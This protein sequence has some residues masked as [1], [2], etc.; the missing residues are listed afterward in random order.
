MFF[1]DPY[2]SPA[3]L[4]QKRPE[5]SSSLAPP[6]QISGSNV[7]DELAQ[8][9]ADL[10]PPPPP[11]PPELPCWADLYADA[12]STSFYEQKLHVPKYDFRLAPRHPDKPQFTTWVDQDA[13]A[14]Y[15]PC[16]RFD[17][18]L[19][20]PSE[21]IPRLK[22]PRL[23][24]TFNYGE[25]RNKRPKTL[26]WQ[27]GRLEGKRLVIIFKFT[28]ARIQAVLEH[29]GDALSNWPG[30][31]F[32]S[33]DG[34]PDWEARWSAQ[35]PVLESQLN[36]D[37]TYCLRDRA[38]LGSVSQN[39]V[40]DG[41]L[42]LEDLT[43]G[44][45]AARGCRACFELGNSCPLL[46]EGTK[47]PCSLCVEDGLDCEL[48]LEPLEK[49]RCTSCTSRRIVCSFAADGKVRG[50]C[51]PCKA[52]GKKC[53]AGPK[54]GRIRTGPALDNLFEAEDQ[55]EHPRAFVTCTEC[56][57]DRKWCSIK[58]KREM[59]PCERCL[60]TGMDCTFEPLNSRSMSRRSRRKPKADQNDEDD[61][62]F[63][64]SA[65]PVA[66]EKVGFKSTSELD[67]PMSSFVT[68]KNAMPV[69]LLRTITTKLAHPIQFNFQPKDNDTLACHWCDD[70]VYGIL[71]LGEKRVEVIDYN[72]GQGFSEVSGGHTGAGYAASRMCDMCTLERIMIAACGIHEMEPIS[73]IDPDDFPHGIVEEHMMPGKAVNAPFQWCSVCPTAA[74]FKCC[75]RSDMD[76]TEIEVEKADGCGLVLCEYCAVT[77]VGEHDGRLEALISTMKAERAD[78]GFGLRA[79]V[80]F[81]HPE[82]ELLR[83]MGSAEQSF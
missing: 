35:P 64:P 57:S 25:Y 48:V 21:C 50:S 77:L 56:R 63:I 24:R 75:K 68:P 82:G 2:D 22:R 65:T 45:P 67:K 73:D 42:R 1:T 23:E 39:E 62:I 9:V 19:R 38:V 51:E 6:A 11:P 15:D 13:T 18:W 52:S 55:V 8:N 29:Y 34:D 60:N 30:T 81:L 70:L 7:T 72:D 28:S 36:L 61:E 31:A 33:A 26:T 58:R 12:L 74:F 66:A 71:G 79:D 14:T 40:D 53:V 54:N 78:D 4:V 80:E 83:R 10:S 41:D 16:D 44:H 59:P 69:G 17:P 27:R 46:Q 76:V 20:P 49:G 47:Y 37:D 5:P 3:N 32:T 43:L